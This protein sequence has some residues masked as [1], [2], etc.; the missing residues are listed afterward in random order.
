MSPFDSHSR[1]VIISGINWID[2]IDDQQKTM[3]EWNHRQRFE[4]SECLQQIS[5]WTMIWELNLVHGENTHVETTNKFV[6]TANIFIPFNLQK[7]FVAASKS[8]CLNCKMGWLN[9]STGDVKLL[10]V[11]STQNFPTGSFFSVY[12]HSL[13]WGIGPFYYRY[14]SFGK[15]LI[16]SLYNI[17]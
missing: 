9:S 10:S 14:W 16:F 11:M 7:M 2:V 12:L 4:M 15:R 1:G 3:C 17:N 13:S 5:S 6:T 8:V